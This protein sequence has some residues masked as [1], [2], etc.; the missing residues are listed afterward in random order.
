M[1]AELNCFSAFAVLLF[2][3]FKHLT[4]FK[5]NADGANISKFPFDFPHTTS[6]LRILAK[7]GQPIFIMPD[8]CVQIV[9]YFFGLTLIPYRKHSL[10][11]L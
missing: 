6:F 1:S 2:L 9:K 7:D 3:Y 11:Q 8:C 10:L 5:E 4:T